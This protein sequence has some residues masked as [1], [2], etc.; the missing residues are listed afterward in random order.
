MVYEIVEFSGL[1]FYTSRSP[2]ICQLINDYYYI[3]NIAGDGPELRDY[4]VEK[5]IIPPLLELV[6]RNLQSHENDENASQNNSFMRNLTW[7]IS[8]LC[9]N[10][11]PSPS[12]YVVRT[13]LPTLFQLTLHP[14]KEVLGKLLCLGIRTLSETGFDYKNYL[15]H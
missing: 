6:H 3:G 15:Q 9:R 14:D 12:V 7:T 4:T 11:N 2:P 1:K 5:G 10:K 13:L 8:N